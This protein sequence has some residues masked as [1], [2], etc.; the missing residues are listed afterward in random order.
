MSALNIPKNLKKGDRIFLG[1]DYQ[2]SE[3]KRSTPLEWRVLEVSGDT[4]LVITEKAP[5]CKVFH[6]IDA[7]GFEKMYNEETIDEDE[8]AEEYCAAWGCCTLREFLNGY[9][10]DELFS[11]EEKKII[12]VSRVEYDEEDGRGCPGECDTEDRLFLLSKAEAEKYFDSQKDRRCRA[13][14]SAAGALRYGGNCNWLLRSLGDAAWIIT[15]VDNEGRI[16]EES[17]PA[18]WPAAV[19]PAMRIKI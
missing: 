11:E 12:T 13:T 15:V 16:D 18:E 4:A 19:R 3:Q 9:L 1:K 7:E 17:S 2:D 6:E 14:D 8:F 10:F 5:F